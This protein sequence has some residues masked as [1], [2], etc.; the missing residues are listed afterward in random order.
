MIKFPH[1]LLSWNLDKSDRLIIYLFGHK[2]FSHRFKKKA[3]KCDPE[4]YFKWLNILRMD[5][6][7][8]VT[9]TDNPYKRKDGDVKVFAYYLPQFHT[10]PENDKAFGRGFTEWTNVAAIQ[11]QYVGHYQP[12]IPFDVG[13]YD[14]RNPCVMQRQVT[15]AKD[16]GVYGFCFYYYWF[17]GKKLLNEPIETFLKSDIDIHFHFCWCNENWSKLWDGGN[18]ETIIKQTLEPED[19][20]KFF[21]DILPYIKDSRYEKISNKPI[22]MIY[23]STIF[24]K[25]IFRNFLISLNSMA[26]KAG[27]DGFFITIAKKAK[28]NV[29]EFDFDAIVEFPPHCMDCKEKAK[30]RIENNA[31]Y[32]V[33]DGDSYIKNRSYIYKSDYRIFKCAFPSWDNLPRKLNSGGSVFEV[34]SDSFREWLKGII[35]WTIKNNPADM[36]YVYINAWN[37]W[38]EGAIL[39]PTTRYGYKNLNILKQTLEEFQK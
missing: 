34:S 5:K 14:L 15:I 22:L 1:S 10:I 23:D 29:K 21:N 28:M 24:N 33:F 13:F 16:Y 38:A 36:Q 32:T 9:Y 26:K 12:K 3:L 7:E 8:F 37:E 27:F 6:S 11:P 35:D 18:R 4:K 25:S 20:E 30:A 2:I 19:A 39:E 17:S 31:K